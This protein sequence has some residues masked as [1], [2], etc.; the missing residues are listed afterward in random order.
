MLFC[1]IKVIFFGFYKKFALNLRYLQLLQEQQ[2]S[3]LL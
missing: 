3:F 2:H 1:E